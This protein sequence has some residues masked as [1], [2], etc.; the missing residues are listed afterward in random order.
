MSRITK[1]VAAATLLAVPLINACGEGPVPPPPAGTISG[2]VMVEGEGLT[3]VTVTLSSGTTVT[4]TN[5][6]AFSFADVEAGTYTVTISGHPGD[7]NFPQTSQSATITD[8]GQT[9][10]VNFNGS[11][12]RTSAIMGSVTVESDGLAGVTVKIAGMA[13]SETLTGTT[14]QYSFTGLRAGSYTVE[15]SG[16]DDEDVGFGA[17]TSTA[18]VAVGESQVVT[19]EGT[20]LRASNIMGQ[21]SIEGAGLAD[22]TVSL[23][24]KGET[25]EMQTNGAGQYL[26]EDLR[27]GDYAIGISGYDDDEYGFETTSK[28]IHVPYGETENVP[29]EGIALRTAEIRGVVEIDGMGPLEGVTVSLTG[30]GDDPDPVVTMGDGRFS[31]DRLHA[32]DYTISI[33]GYDTDE[34]G[35]D[36]TSRNVTV[37][38]K[39]T[40]SLEFDGIMLRTAAIEG[41]V[42]IKG[43]GLG[44][45]TVTVAGGPKD[46]EHEATTNGAGMYDVGDL[47]AGDYSVTIS[48]YD[49]KEYGFEVTTKSVS[50]GLRETAEVAFD[51]ILLR[52]AGVSGR[53]T[54]AGE[55]MSGWTVALSGEEDRDGVKTNANGQ[56]GFSGLAAGDYTIT[57]SGYDTD[58]YEFDAEMDI[59][60]ELDEAAIAN[61]DGRSLRTVVVMGTVSAEGDALMNVGVT[62]IKVLGANTGE[63]LGAMMTDED[64]GYMFDELLAGIY[65]IELGETD[66]EYDF[67]TKSRMGKVAT[68]DTAA[69]NFDADIIRTASVGGMVTVDGDGMAD[70]M[71]MLTGDHG[72]E[73]EMETGSGGSYMFEGLRKGDYTVS[74]ENPDDGTYDFP[75]TERMVSLA[76]GQAQEDISFAGS[77]L[78]R[79]SISGQVHVEGMGLEGVT[80]TLDGDADAEMM[81]DANGEYNFPGLA[82][83]DYEIEIENPDADAYIFE[84]MEMDVDDLGDEEA[85]IVDFAGEHTTTASVSG[86]LF[87]DEVKVDSMYTEGEPVLPFDS[88]PL[89]LQG[90]GVN[91]SRIGYTD[92]TGEYSFDGL[93]A[94]TYNVVVS[95]NDRLKAALSRAGY[96]FSGNELNIGIEVPAATDVDLN[97]PFRITKQT[98][99]AGAFLHAGGVTGYPVGGVSMAL[100]PTAEDAED[101]TNSLGTA[102]TKSGKPDDAETGFAMF[103]F[104]RAKD[105]GPGGTPIDYLVYAK[106]TRVSNSDLMVHNDALIEIEYEAV[107]RAT[108]APAAV[109]LINT[110]VNFQWWVKSNAT[111]KDGNQFL[112]G[113]KAKNGMT[114]NSRGLAT[115]SGKLSATQIAAAI[116]GTPARFTVSL[117]TNQA[118][119]VDGRERWTQSSSL[120]HTHTGLENPSTNTTASN[121]LGAIH[122]TWQTH[123][124]VLGV[125]R[126]ADDV[127]GYTNYQSRLPGGDHRPVSS[128]AGRMKITALAEDDRGR[129]KPYKYDHDACWNT[130]HRKT[131]PIE[132][133]FRISNGLARVACLPRNDE[134]TIKFVVDTASAPNRV[135]V[136]I[137]AEKLHG[138]LEPYN[139]S[140]MTV[141]GSTVGTFGDGSGGVPEVRICLSSEGTTDKECATWGYQWET[142]SIVGNVGDQSGHKLHIEPTTE[143]HGADTASSSSGTSGAYKFGGLRDGVYDI[144]AYDT[145]T[146]KVNGKATQTDLVVYHDETTDD[147]DTLTKFVGTAAQDTARWSTTRLGLR[148]MGYI[149][150]DGN[151]DG[152]F[153]GDEAVAGI[154]VRLSGAGVSKS[155]TTDEHGFYRFDDLPAGRYTIG[156]STSSYEVARGYRILGTS[157]IAYTSWSASAQDYPSSAKPTEGDV[158]LPYWTSYT[159]RSLSNSTSR[160]CNTANPP[161]CGTLYNFGMLYKDGEIEGAVNNLS[162]SASGID[163]IWTDVFTDRTQDITTNFRGE[164]TRTRL[165]EGDY[166]VKIEDA[167]WAV[168]RLN[169]RG[170]PD[171]DGTTTA[172]STVSASVRGKD[173]FETMTLHVYDAGASS[174]D[175][176]RSARVS[177]RQHGTGTGFDSAVSWPAGWLRGSGT[178]TTSNLNNLGVIS[179]KSEGVRLSFSR[180]RGATYTLKNGST[181]CTG[182]TCTLTYN[183]TGST[184]EGD[185]R[186][187]TLN[188]MVTAANGYDDHEYSL[189]VSRAAPVGNEMTREHFLRVDVVDGEDVETAAIGDGDGKS[190]H[191]A[192]TMNTKNATGSSLTMRIDLEVLGVAG[193]SNAYCAQSAM[194]REYNDTDTVKSL[195]PPDQDNYEDDV[196]R[197]SRYRLRVPELYEI[198]IKSEDGVAETYYISTRNRDKS[199]NAEL[200]SLEIAG[201]DISLVS[202]DTTYSAVEAAAQVTVEWETAD[203]NASVLATPRDADTSEDGHQFDLGDPNEVDTLT[204]RVISEDREDTLHYVLDIQRANNVA[205]L[206]SLSA[207]VGL[208]EDFDSET[209][210]YT[211]DADHDDAEVVF[212]F[213]QTDTDG[214]T[215]PTSPHTATLGAAGSSTTVS[216]VSTAEDGSTSRTYTVRVTRAATPP[217]ATAGIVLKDGD[218]NTLESITITEGVTDTVMAELEIEP[219]ADSTVTVAVTSANANVTVDAGASLSFDD[220]NWD[221]GQEVVLTAVDDADAEPNEA[222]EIYFA[223]SGD[224][225]EGYDD[226]TDTVAVA[227]PETDTKGVNFSATGKE[228]GVNNAEA[229]RQYTVV[230]NSQPTGNV[231]IEIDGDPSNVTLSASQLDFTT[232]DWNTAQTVTITPA[233]GAPNSTFAL[234]HEPGG[235]GYGDVSVDD[236]D[237]QI[238]DSA[239]AQV[240]VTTTA[241]TVNELVAFTYTIALAKEPSTDETVTVDLNYSTGDFT[242]T[243]TVA[244]TSSNFQA[245]ETVTLTARNVA[246]D[247]V[248]TISYTVS[249]ADTDTG[250]GSETVYPDSTT[251]SPTS[252]TVKNVP[253]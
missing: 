165:T 110:R 132:P 31:F 127:E 151:R 46:E 169:S 10:T 7:A 120:S 3:G 149:G 1:L 121:D 230:L 176:A 200:E 252:V 138:Y 49:T 27:R 44:N 202:G 16:F 70:V 25:R 215:N 100:Y 124:L 12:I 13:E 239:I 103:E 221:T 205:T 175:A 123:A 108:L 204:I 238:R 47:H 249:V 94:G 48:G 143:N 139:E 173:D 234:S 42:T 213:A 102:T 18:D 220:S 199:S 4:T 40:A 60:L 98:I 207:D 83:G 177:A 231:S 34:Y 32:G 6:G 90:P 64:G 131:D 141:S 181:A 134:F 187:N 37:A 20:Y 159:R 185:P 167:G 96:A 217:A 80:V 198:Q 45:V 214:S 104:D 51:G 91:D 119:S 172:P 107:D 29:F 133:V 203:E 88:F 227:I 174:D 178:E 168:P 112:G 209:T 23:Q 30:K 28:S 247:A 26:F 140:D 246:A 130:N 166:S 111:A 59:V 118:D 196:C 15:I 243:T 155:T 160:Y 182:T 66:E 61:F 197:D 122:I 218:G 157:R 117:D 89:L 219:T 245:G 253:E 242:G 146:Y 136:G 39:E 226:L 52:T 56:Y 201:D 184:N 54:V 170:E 113:W 19:F 21:V 153:R 5:G 191:D 69:W 106:V 190:V 240:V 137:V 41:M 65:R 224:A 38:L 78:R 8:D 210:S 148:L 233:A 74:I 97:L 192:F 183:R 147:K 135:E 237:V 35:F 211:A 163:L 241:V 87:A 129:D 50:V 33:F 232:T 158:G 251:A 186:E 142:G 67:A 17:T 223:M 24:G 73:M 171:D 206:A 43:D 71:V 248:K 164:F 208:N 180:G 11:W 53:V 126:E 222:V 86:M 115:Y 99:H 116:R 188:L 244:L 194:V 236:V 212:T 156:P 14:G 154:S 193:E 81:T 77:M 144:T 195:N 145:R 189:K 2:S 63:V 128:V 125:Y 62:L 93:K 85:R 250:A 9:V 150:H 228:V 92:T 216:I 76:V 58:E 57:L 101:G 22:V 179:W 72:T 114:T 84:V 55:P 79:A 225:G 161:K 109:K 75:T 152:R 235:G 82:G 36:V 95:L 162:G 229:T 68:D 105:K